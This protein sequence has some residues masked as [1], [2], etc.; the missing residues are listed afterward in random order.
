MVV[1][2]QS[3]AVP[4]QTCAAIYIKDTCNVTLELD[5]NK[6][7]SDIY[8]YAFSR[9]FYPKRLT[10]HSGYTFFLSVC[11]FP[12][13]WT[14]DLLRCS[15]NALPLSHRNTLKVWKRQK[16]AYD[17]GDR[18]Y[19]YFSARSPAGCSC[20]AWSYSCCYCCRTGFHRRPWKGNLPP[21]LEES[22]GFLH[23]SSPPPPCCCRTRCAPP[24]APPSELL[25]VKRQL[26]DW[27][28]ARRAA[29]ALGPR[30]VLHPRRATPA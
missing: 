23:P 27:R 3:H 19:L 16:H 13:I 28:A 8:I 1:H 15:R 10:V 20:L 6:T 11:A 18:T 22:P 25:S 2:I 26:E 24:P 14:H 4:S 21:L 29:M 17:V 9:R 12:G 5:Q 7:I 30:R